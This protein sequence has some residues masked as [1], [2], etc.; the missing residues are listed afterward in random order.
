MSF[1][2]WMEAVA[3]ALHAIADVGP[4]DIALFD[5]RAAHAA[6]LTPMGAALAALDNE[7]MWRVARCHSGP[8]PERGRGFSHFAACTG[9]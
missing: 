8:A 4:G 5:Y 3:Q 2:R 1:E 7:L 9:I 6:G